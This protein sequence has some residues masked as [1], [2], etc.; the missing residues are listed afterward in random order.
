MTSHRPNY[1]PQPAEYRELHP[2]D[3][4]VARRE[5]QYL[6]RYRVTDAE[7]GEMLARALEAPSWA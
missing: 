2:D 7:Y 6:A 4:R 5:D 3:A 1:P